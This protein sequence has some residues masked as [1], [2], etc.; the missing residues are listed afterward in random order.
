MN[1]NFLFLIISAIFFGLSIIT[2]V[3]APIINKAHV[4]FFEGW[5]TTNCQKLEDALDFEK[6][7]GTYDEYQS[8]LTVKEREIDECKIHNTMNGLEYACLIID[9]S[10]GFIIAFLALINYIEPENNQRK[11]IGILGLIIGV[12]CTVITCV[13]LGYSGYIFNTE[14]VR[15]IPIL[16][17]NK[18]SWKWNG[19]RYVADYDEYS[20]DFDDKFI[21]IK[22]LSKKQYNYDSDI[23]KAS[24]DSKSDYNKCRANKA[25]NSKMF[26]QGDKE[27]E[28]IWTKDVINNSEEN[29]FLY[30]RWVSSIFFSAIM[31]VCGICLGIFGFLIF[32]NELKE[33]G[34]E[35]QIP[36]PITSYTNSAHRLKNLKNENSESNK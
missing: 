28:Y 31:C 15:N 24:I 16:Y 4:S 34:L 3:I 26:Y 7:I 33:G 23:Y 13:Y 9:F 21:K 29:K 6:S 20:N 12:I 11:K 36:V 2:I 22:D 5:G 14:P 35:S 10:L 30:D 19:I 25:P 32:K 18:A 1:N 8:T 17:A 27:C